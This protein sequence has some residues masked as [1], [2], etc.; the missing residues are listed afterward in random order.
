M[1]VHHHTHPSTSSGNRKKWTHYFWE[2]L[3]LFLAVFCGFLAEYQLEHK[4]EKDREHQYINSLI[5]DIKADTARINLVIRNRNQREINLDSVSLLLNSSSPNSYSSHLYFFAVSVSRTLSFRFLP[6]DGTM[7]QLKNSGGF[8]LIKNPVIADSI[9][10]YDVSIRTMIRQGELEEQMIQ[11]YRSI[12]PKFFNALVFDSLQ[13]ANNNP[14]R[15]SHNPP[16]LDFQKPD[17]EVMNYRLYSLKG[18]NK[19][20]RRDMKSLLRQSEN[21]L[22]LLKKK[23]NL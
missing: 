19:A 11:D 6:N 10:K 14:F 22:V 8:R 16:L 21:L 2:F 12:A 18:L 7:Q 9:A 5:S 1:E 13:D 17:L 20:M 3:M 4:I 23:Y 15:L